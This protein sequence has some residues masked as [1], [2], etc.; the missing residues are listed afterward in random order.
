[1][2]LNRLFKIVVRQVKQLIELIK[3]ADVIIVIRRDLLRLISK[4]CVT[5]GNKS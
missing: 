3:I 2:Y 5:L 4:I 1:M